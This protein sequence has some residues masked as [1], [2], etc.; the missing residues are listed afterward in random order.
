MRYCWDEK[1]RLSNLRDHEID[2]VDAQAVFE[3]ATFT[4]PDDRYPYHERRFV[5]LGLLNGLPV[6]IAHTETE[7]EI[8]VI[9]FRKATDNETQ[10]LFSQIQDQLPPPKVDEKPR[11]SADRRAPRGKPKEHRR[12][13]RK[14]RPK[15]RSP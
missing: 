8:R 11:R 12:R 3:G 7:D 14:A 1:K 2:F 5:T 6:S 9:S 10:I 15:G 4:Y 13:D